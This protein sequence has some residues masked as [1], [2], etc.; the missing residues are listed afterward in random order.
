ME[1][2]EF[3][4]KSVRGMEWFGLLFADPNLPW[5]AGHRAR[6]FP[7][8]IYLAFSNRSLLQQAL[9]PNDCLMSVICVDFSRQ[10]RGL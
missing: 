8:T 6:F 10:G 1:R 7:R 2:F 5:I 3:V 9:S 4:F